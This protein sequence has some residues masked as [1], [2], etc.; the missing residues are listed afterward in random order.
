MLL[1]PP[2]PSRLASGLLHALPCNSRDSHVPDRRDDLA[3]K[4]PRDLWPAILH[5]HP[6]VRD[7]LEWVNLDLVPFMLL[8]DPQKAKGQYMPQY[9]SLKILNQD[10][11]TIIPCVEHMVFWSCADLIR[12]PSRL[13]L[14]RAAPGYVAFHVC[15]W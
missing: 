6:G 13:E 1:P 2:L 4:L 5:I 3:P 9:E 12:G 7:Q 10:I 8:V 14:Q 11:Q 15:S